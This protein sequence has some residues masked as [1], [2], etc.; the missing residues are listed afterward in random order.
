[1]N[2]YETKTKVQL[3]NMIRLRNVT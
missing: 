3:S 2:T 1:M